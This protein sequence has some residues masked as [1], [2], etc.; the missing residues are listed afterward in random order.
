MFGRKTAKQTFAR[1]AAYER[2][3]PRLSSNRMSFCKVFLGDGTSFAGSSVIFAV[4][5]KPPHGGA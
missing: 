5:I 2:F 3:E 4:D 1:D